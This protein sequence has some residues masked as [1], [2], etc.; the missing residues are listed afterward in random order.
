VFETGSY[1]VA[2]DGFELT[3]L[4]PQP[5]SPESWDYRCV[6]PHLVGSLINLI[7]SGKLLSG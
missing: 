7:L 6:P 1:F 5:Q 2:Q 3:T 4:V